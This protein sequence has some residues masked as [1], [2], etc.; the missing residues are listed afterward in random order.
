MRAD[1]MPPQAVPLG[2]DA[3]MESTST[4]PDTANDPLQDRVHELADE[5]GIPGVAVGMF[6][7][8]EARYAF[9][10]VTSVENPLPVD[11]TTLFQFGSIGKTY[12][13][14]ALLRLVEAGKVDLDAPVRRYV[15]E[16]TLRDSA[17]AESVTVLQLL[18]HTA[19]WDGDFFEDTGDGDDAL[20][21]YVEGMASLHQ[22]SPPGSM[23]SYNNAAVALAGRIIEKVTGSTYE[24]AVQELVLDPVGLGMTFFFPNDVMTRRFA[25]GHRI[26]ADG[27]PRVLRPW[28]MPRS[29]N[30]M[31]G[32]AASA[33]D[34]LRWA[35]FH[36]DR[37]R[38]PEGDQVL[39]AD[40]IERMRRPTVESRGS[41]LG[42]AI[43]IS[44]F[45]LDFDGE[46]VLTHGG[47]TNGQFALS[48]MAPDRRFAIVS[49]TNAEPTG[50]LF[51]LLIRQWALET[52][53]GLKRADPVHEPRP[54]DELAAYAGTYRIF[55]DIITV[56]VNGDHLLAKERDTP[57]VIAQ[58][59]SD[60][61]ADEP[62]APMG[63]LPGP[64]DR[65]VVP[66]GPSRGSKGFFTRDGDGHIIG[67]HFHG[68][69][70]P[71]VES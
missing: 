3:V 62:P 59:G 66:S 10:G 47:S 29:G 61:D 70:V 25:V 39:S 14:V 37:G 9:R 15:P 50:P 34:Q 40:L 30:P 4:S 67:I 32:L 6:H 68:R 42:D 49:L 52:Y 24:R 57:E 36:L 35:R 31:G 46:R 56:T 20:A 8:E 7:E 13:S 64:G 58:L 22:Y 16:L 55:S 2:H 18:N 60:V 44:W 17:A 51:N 65:W 63:M 12:T 1:P 45:L 54:A 41:G 27:A 19:G 28:A 23:V 5:L 11:A 71:R 53:L 69:F 38:T 48:T 43:G 33:P 21:R 26:E